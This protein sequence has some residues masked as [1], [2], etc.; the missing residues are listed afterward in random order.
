MPDF[1]D[2]CV[3]PDATIA[4]AIEILER[5]QR[6][7]VVVVDGAGKLVGTLTDGDLR[8]AFYRGL[9]LTASVRDALPLVKPELRETPVWARQHTD[10]TALSAL[11]E[12]HDVLQIPLLDEDDRVVDIAFREASTRVPE[13]VQAVIMAG[14]LG[15]RLRPL[16]NETPKPLLQVGS[17]PVVDHLLHQL[18]DSGVRKVH[19]TTHYLPDKIRDHIGSGESFGVEVNYVSETEPLGTAGALGLLQDR[20]QTLLVVNGDVLTNVN[21]RA[22][23]AYHR[24]QR[25]GAT[26]GVAAHEV[27]VPFGVVETDGDRVVGIAEK[28]V[29]TY[30]VNAG[31]YVLEPTALAAIPSS[32]RLDMTDL[33]AVLVA[34]GVKVVPFPITEYWLDVGRE[35]DLA[36]ANADAASGR[37]HSPVARQPGTA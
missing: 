21:F 30:F 16:T 33:V 1:R 29:Y 24:E 34:S 9:A 7:I 5:N 20:Q 10:A 12:A 3:P 11:F 36:A 25:A 8:R 15:K 17:A 6:G 13:A 22:L 4:G 37:F 19:I 26:V 35:E 31:I 14:G 2:F 18:H 27:A 28:P 23:I 32:A